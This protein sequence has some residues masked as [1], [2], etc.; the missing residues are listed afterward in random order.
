MASDVEEYDGILAAYIG[1]TTP[2]EA[3]R[4]A[5]KWVAGKDG[6]LTINAIRWDKKAFD[7]YELAIYYEPIDS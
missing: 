7:E 2:A 4:A 1:G 5:A 3:F 6:A